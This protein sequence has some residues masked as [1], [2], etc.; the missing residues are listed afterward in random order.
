MYEQIT[1]EDLCPDE[2]AIFLKNKPKFSPEVVTLFGTDEAISPAHIT[3]EHLQVD[4][5]SL[6]Q[7]STKSP[8]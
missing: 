5:R 3:D 4:Y 7:L 8:I 6:R 2:M 1:V